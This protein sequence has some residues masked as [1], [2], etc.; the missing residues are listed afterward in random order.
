MKQKKIVTHLIALIIGGLLVYLMCCYKN[1]NYI[2]G[3][4]NRIEAFGD[5]VGQNTAW[6]WIYNYSRHRVTNLRTPDNQP[7]KSFFIEKNVI[8]IIQQN[9]ATIKGLQCY[10][11]KRNDNTST[12]DYTLIMIPT[13]EDGTLLRTDGKVT[14]A[15]DWHKPCPTCNEDN[16]GS[17][18]NPPQ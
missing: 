10:F 18:P 12:T 7:L 2:I 5:N 3:A 11:A 17:T 6:T 14:Y 4:P 1:T 15:L 9:A 8:D 16:F 13:S